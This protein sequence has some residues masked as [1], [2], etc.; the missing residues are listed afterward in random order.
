MGNINQNSVQESKTSIYLPEAVDTN[1]T[2]HLS[3]TTSVE[4]DAFEL[5][6]LFVDSEDLATEQ[7]TSWKDEFPE[8]F[9]RKTGKKISSGQ[10]VLLWN[11]H[12]TNMEKLKKNM[13][14]G[15]EDLKKPVSNSR[16]KTK[17][18]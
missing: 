16:R 8:V 11:A 3:R 18:K 17:K 14:V 6:Q 10:S 13:F 5:D 12:R 9:H 7:A 1:F 15:Y 2:I 4:I